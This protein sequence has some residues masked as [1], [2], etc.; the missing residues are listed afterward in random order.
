MPRAAIIGPTK[1]GAM[2]RREFLTTAVVG[3][4]LATVG[5]PVFLRRAYA[6]NPIKIGLP[7]ARQLGVV[8]APA[9][10]G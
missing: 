4:A 3:S 10:A 9:P 5:A 1:E 8:P 2:K 7:A 6:Q